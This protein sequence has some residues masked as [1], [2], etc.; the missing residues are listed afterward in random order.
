MLIMLIE[1]NSAY[2]LHVI[3]YRCIYI[4]TKKE[5]TQ[6]VANYCIWGKK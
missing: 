5:T 3:P 1:K 2:T 4:P 6:N